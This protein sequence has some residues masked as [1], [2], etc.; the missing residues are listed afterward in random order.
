MVAINIGIG[1]MGFGLF[2][3]LFGVLLYFD[4]VLL[5]FGNMLFLTGLTSIIGFRRTSYFFFQRHKLKGSFFFMGGVSLVLCRWP[6][7]GMLVES[8]GFILLFRIC[9]ADICVAP[10]SGCIRALPRDN[11][12]TTWIKPKPIVR[13]VSSQ[14]DL[15]LI[16]R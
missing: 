16:T 13:R 10:S 3:L 8:Y 5:A 7:I 6:V 12:I 2:F 1:L 4:S 11:H 15:R 14:L 9:V